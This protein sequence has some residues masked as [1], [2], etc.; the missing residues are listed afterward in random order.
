MR[1]ATDPRGAVT[2]RHAGITR[3]LAL[4]LGT[5]VLGLAGCASPAPSEDELPAY[6]PRVNPGRLPN[7]ARV[8]II[9]LM[10]NEIS[11]VRGGLVGSERHTVRANS[12]LAGFTTQELRKAILGKTPYQPV[13][14]NPTSALLK[15]R[16]GWSQQWTGSRFQGELQRDFESILQQNQLQ[17]IIVIAHEEVSS[18]GFGGP[19][20]LGSGLI[21]LD[22]LGSRKVGVF[23]SLRFFR[24]YGG[25]LRLMQPVAAPE[26]RVVADLPNVQLPDD[27]DDL[28]PRYFTPVYEPLRTLIKQKIG[29]AVDLM[30]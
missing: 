16:D 25:P 6:V 20:L 17:A 1:S 18:R 28:H 29:E 9:N 30:R 13:P 15:N 5:L 7:G 4:M 19:T 8:G 11:H 3:W 26:E 24:V 10:Q 22:R 21:T 27:L 23:S 12:D 2:V 14:L